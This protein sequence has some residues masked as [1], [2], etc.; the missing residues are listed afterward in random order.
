MRSRKNQDNQPVVN[1]TF[2][3]NSLG[4]ALLG[5][6]AS[7]N[8][9]GRGREGWFRFTQIEAYAG[10]NWK[11]NPRLTLELG[12]RY[13]LMQPQYASLNNAVVF[14]Q[15]YYD[16]AKAPQ[17]NPSNGYLIAGS[18]DAVN[19]LAAGGSG[20]PEAAMQRIK[21]ASTNPLYKTLFRGLPKEIMPWSGVWSP[22]VSFALDLFG[23]QTT[24]LRGGFGMFYERIQ[25]NYVFS[26][27]NNPPFLQ[28]TT[29]YNAN[30]ENPAGGTTRL[31]PQNIRSFDIGMKIPV[32]QNWSFGIQRKITKDT[33]LD[34]AYVGSNAYHQ[35]ENIR[36]NQLKG[37]T[38][39]ANPGINTNALRPYRGYAD[40]NQYVTSA[41]FNYHSMQLLFKRS[42]TS[43]GLVNASYTWSKTLTDSSGWSDTVMD[44]YNPYLDRALANY[45]RTHVLVVSY[46]YPLPFWRQSKEWYAKAFGG[47][48]I[49]G[50]TTI[51]SGMPTDVTV[52]GDPAGIGT[53]GGQRPNVS[54]SWDLDNRTTQKW[55]ETS[56]FS[57]PTAGTWGKLGKNAIRRPGANNWD[58]SLQKFFSIT[59]QAK[60]SFRLEM[61]NAPNHINYWTLATTVGNSNFGQ[62]T[63]F[64]DMRIL[65]MAM[66]LQF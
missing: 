6:F 52:N 33:M 66:R 14:D 5:N 25:G 27:I 4:E 49:S 22:R 12:L 28:D 54:G 30:V 65:Q 38:L 37:G 32:V 7:Y 13:N 48:Q 50:V 24:V 29:V 17:I 58:L 62:V 15:K 35:T 42:F 46:I 56:V 45:D 34:V 43:A 16:P 23:N 41:N 60:F 18:Y 57:V 63:A 20:F 8:E 47:W 59:E 19:G 61:Y 51:Q 36:L 21:D 11:V 31:L 40:I 39:Q 55:F 3:F 44:T 9:A 53:T 2:T 10:D 64:L 1:G 26:N